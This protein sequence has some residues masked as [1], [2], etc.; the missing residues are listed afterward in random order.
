[1]GAYRH[2]RERGSGR[3]SLRVRLVQ[4]VRSQTAAAEDGALASSIF[5]R[6]SAFSVLMIP[7]GC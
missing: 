3:F 2:G 4:A 6:S 5:A 7:P 1:M